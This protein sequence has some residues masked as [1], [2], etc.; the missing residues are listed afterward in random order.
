MATTSPNNLWS[1]DSGDAY[2]LTVHLRAMV[3]TVQSALNTKLNTET[4]ETRVITSFGN[5]FNA[6]SG[7]GWS[8]LR[9]YR[10][11]GQV[12]IVGSVQKDSVGGV[13]AETA[14]ASI[15]VGWRPPVKWQ[16]SSMRVETGGNLITENAVNAN[17][18]ISVFANYPAT[19]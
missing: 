13:P 9:A 17:Q 2:D 10:M 1:P 14:F 19:Q 18:A 11:Y 6:Y 4:L 16:G 8:G 12:W 15:P 5:G 7:F 3:D